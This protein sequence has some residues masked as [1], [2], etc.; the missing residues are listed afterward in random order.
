MDSE[1]ERGSRLLSPPLTVS[2]ILLPKKLSPFLLWKILREKV[3]FSSKIAPL[4]VKESQIDH[5]EF[6]LFLLLR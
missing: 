6:F 5:R 4:D 2:P 1:E 3:C